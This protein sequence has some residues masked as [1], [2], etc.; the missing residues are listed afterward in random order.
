MHVPCWSCLHKGSHQPITDREQQ[1][2]SSFLFHLQACYQA[3]NFPPPWVAQG[4]LPLLLLIYLYLLWLSKLQAVC[5]KKGKVSSAAS[6][7]QKPHVVFF[8]PI[9][10]LSVPRKQT[11]NCWHSSNFPLLSNSLSCCSTKPTAFWGCKVN[12]E[13]ASISVLS[14]TQSSLLLNT[15]ELA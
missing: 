8:F 9:Q 11:S 4:E 2:R 6:P 3:Q 5:I 13:K 14:W 10:F 12:A 1:P 7:S 15:S